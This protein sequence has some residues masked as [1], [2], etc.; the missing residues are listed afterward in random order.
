VIS[1]ALVHVASVAALVAVVAVGHT[2]AVDT[3]V[4]VATVVV[5]IVVVATFATAI[6]TAAVN[7]SLCFVTWWFPPVCAHLEARVINATLFSS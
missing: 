3:V 7:C 2:V 5:A 6:E 1:L 4:V